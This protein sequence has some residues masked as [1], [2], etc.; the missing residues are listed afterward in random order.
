MINKCLQTKLKS[1][2]AN[3]N[4]PVLGYMNIKTL[5]GTVANNRKM[6]VIF[7]S[8]NQ[9]I[10]LVGNIHFTDSGYTED[11]GKTY[12]LGT[13]LSADIY[14]S[15]GEGKVMIPKYK[16]IKID[17]HF[18]YDGTKNFEFDFGEIFSPQLTSV[19]IQNNIFK[20]IDGLKNTAL[21]ELYLGGC[22][23]VP[24]ENTGFFSSLDSLTVLN[25][26]STLQ[27]NFPTIY[28]SYFKNNYV[29]TELNCQ[30]GDSITGELEDMCEGICVG[31][32]SGTL[33]IK[34]GSITFNNNTFDG[35]T[36]ATI[37]FSATGCTVTINGNTSTYTK[38]SGTWTYA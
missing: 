24:G 5:Q 28:V 10:K 17:T 6:R 38:S 11:R 31:R 19:R 33:T 15:D 37:T 22:T 27:T 13:S 36:T 8:T 26:N 25:V 30:W 1:E 20:N 14:I 21:T 16:L 7:S 29:L 4:L 3:D 32:T 35:S 2:V 34:G 9:V 18:N 12:N 23:G